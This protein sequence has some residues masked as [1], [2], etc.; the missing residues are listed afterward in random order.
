MTL[1]LLLRIGAMNCQQRI[2]AHLH[3]VKNARL[4][5]YNDELAQQLIPIPRR[6]LTLLMALA[7]YGAAKPWPR[8]VACRGYIAGI[9]SASGRDG[10]SATDACFAGRTAH[11]GWLDPRLASEGAGLTPIREWGWTRRP[12]FNHT[13]KSCQ[14]SR[15]Y[16]G[17]PDARVIYRSQRYAGSARRR[18]RARC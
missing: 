12:A 11:G 15:T 2:P 10:S 17:I 3:T 6:Y 1:S 8:Y 4:I 5:W 18:K 7:F 9:S 16:L 13:R 14:R